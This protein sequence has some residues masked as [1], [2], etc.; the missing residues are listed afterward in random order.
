MSVCRMML[1]LDVSLGDV[2]VVKTHCEAASERQP[3]QFTLALVSLGTVTRRA[4]LLRFRGRLIFA[5]WNRWTFFDLKGLH[6]RRT[7]RLCPLFLNPDG[8]IST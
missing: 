2:Q 8:C 5:P 1:Y 4:K 7:L 3:S 6:S